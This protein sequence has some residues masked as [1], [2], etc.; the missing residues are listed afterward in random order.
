[1]VYID[2]YQEI[3]RE[4]PEREKGVKDEWIYATF[5]D[6]TVLC[7]EIKECSHVNE[8]MFSLCSD[9]W[10]GC[11]FYKYKKHE[12]KLKSLGINPE[13]KILE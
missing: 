4:F 12:R 11:G 10:E 7:P 5:F 3:G 6:I 13:M 1:M 2:I 8:E 9:N